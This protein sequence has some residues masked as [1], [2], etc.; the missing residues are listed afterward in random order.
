[1]CITLKVLNLSRYCRTLNDEGGGKGLL[2]IV[3]CCIPHERYQGGNEGSLRLDNW[4]F[5]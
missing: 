4:I 2:F 1:M 3:S 5:R